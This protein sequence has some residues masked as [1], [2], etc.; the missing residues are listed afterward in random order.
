[1]PN[2]PVC[3]LWANPMRSGST[4][5]ATENGVSYVLCGLRLAMAAP[6]RQ[7]RPSPSMMRR[8]GGRAR[9]QSVDTLAPAP[10][11]LAGGRLVKRGFRTTGRQPCTT[12][13][14]RPDARRGV[15]LWGSGAA[16]AA[17]RGLPVQDRADDVEKRA[18][19]LLRARPAFARSGGALPGGA[20]YPLR[21]SAEFRVVCF[22]LLQA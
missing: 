2:S 21:S 15:R 1:M 8:G 14:R 17:R 20:G 19:L 6:K 22:I 9:A 7:L 12:R 18:T 3:R 11:C 10:I 4:R 16:A 13:N 5:G